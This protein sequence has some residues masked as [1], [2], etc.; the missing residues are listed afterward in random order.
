MNLRYQ[1]CERIFK[2]ETLKEKLEKICINCK[3][4]VP[5]NYGFFNAEKGYDCHVNP[6]KSNYTFPSVR[7]EDFCKEWEKK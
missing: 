7:A 6:P 3:W 1:F 5:Y 4:C 2:E